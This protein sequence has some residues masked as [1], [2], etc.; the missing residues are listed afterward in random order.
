[1]TDLPQYYKLMRTLTQVASVAYAF[2]NETLRNLLGYDSYQ[3]D[4]L[5]ADEVVCLLADREPQ[6][7][8]QLSGYT[9]RQLADVLLPVLREFKTYSETPD[10][11]LRRLVK[12]V[13]VE[14]GDL[15]D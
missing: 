6:E 15:S 14:A 4:S 2:R 11:T 12:A 8:S 13:A 7:F 9:T 5:L 3:L 1:M 10:D